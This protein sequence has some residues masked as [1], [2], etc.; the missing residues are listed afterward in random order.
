MFTR[1]LHWSLSWARSI[2]SIPHHPNSA[3][4]LL[5][6]SS[7]LCPGLPCG[8]YP[9]GFPTKI[10]Y[11]FL[12]SP[13]RATCPVHLDLII[14]IIFGEEYKLWSSSLCSF[15]NLLSLHPSSV[16]IF[17]SAPCSQTPS[18]YV[19]PLISET[20]FHT[21]TERQKVNV[22]VHPAR[23][24]TFSFR[25][26]V[27]L[28]WDAWRLTF[29]NSDNSVIRFRF[30]LRHVVLYKILPL[31]VTMYH[32]DLPQTLQDLGGWANPVIADYFEDYAHLLY[33]L[34]GDRV[35]FCLVP[36]VLLSPLFVL[37]L[38]S[39]TL[40]FSL[41]MATGRATEGSEFESW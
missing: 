2:Q 8:L 18:V 16:Q 39:H 1:A 24:D 7:H 33:T 19:P 5:I 6:L 35:S 31:Q 30:L 27:L 23:S 20:K 40:V 9:S 14:L 11:E 28:V 17:S 37:I 3:T 29:R 36:C 22:L 10:I 38:P 26:A 13:I 25:A 32:W 21:R 34:F 15:S 4:S 41:Y 12:L